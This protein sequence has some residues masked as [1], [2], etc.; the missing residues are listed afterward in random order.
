MKRP[1]RKVIITLAIA[2]VVVILLGAMVASKKR[3]KPIPITTDK[4][5]RKTVTQQPRCSSAFLWQIH[6][7]GY[8]T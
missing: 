3:E 2:V 6:H 7:R 1:S 4:A 5:F 8:A